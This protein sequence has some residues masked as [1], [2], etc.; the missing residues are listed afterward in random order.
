[1]VLNMVVTPIDALPY[2]RGL[3]AVLAGYEGYTKGKRRAADKA[4]RNELIRAARRT[5]NHMT[6]L[7]DA[8]ATA[9]RIELA[10]AAKRCCSTL[11]IFIEDVSKASSGL[12]RSFF[13][14]Q[15]ILSNTDLKRLIHHD[16]QVITM[17]TKATNIANAAERKY[18]HQGESE[19]IERLIHR[20]QQMVTSS[21]GLFSERIMILDGLRQ[22]KRRK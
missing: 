4:I 2:L 10:M 20:C 22:R 14:G 1:M 13:S 8:A 12:S 3:Q 18:G 16:H 21:G 7:H 15:R 17:V 11:D 6:N 19:E 9:S 5:R